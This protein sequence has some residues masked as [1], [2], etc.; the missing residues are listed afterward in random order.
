MI[1]KN[2][3]GVILATIVLAAVAAP[4]LARGNDL[5]VKDG[6]GDQVGVKHGF[7]G[8]KTVVVKD[9]LGDGYGTKSGFFG[10]KETDV[11]VLG[12]SYKRQ[13]GWFGGST[14][15]GSTIL[16]DKVSTKKGI[17][18]RRTTTIDASGTSSVLQG[19]WQKNK[20]KILGTNPS[21]G[22]LGT[23]DGKPNSEMLQ[24]PPSVD[25]NSYSGNA[26]N[27]SSQY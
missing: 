5:V 9:R 27:G 6:F 3:N 23:V 25:S 15:S 1:R 4:V 14:V 10:T 13:R 24:N 22:N 21:T 26:G 19:L 16:G 2:I 17:F 20:S 11:N 8:H 12:N 18:G 7:F